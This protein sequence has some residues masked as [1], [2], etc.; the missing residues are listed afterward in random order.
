MS[1]LFDK[2]RVLIKE[3]S[4]YKKTNISKSISLIEEAISLCP[5]YVLSDYYKLSSYYHLAGKKNKAYEL[6]NQQ[7][8]YLNENYKLP[9]LHSNKA[10]IYE[11]IGVLLYSDKMYNEYIYNFS[12]E[13]FN[14][15][16]S[17]FSQGRIHDY[18]ESKESY[19][20]MGLSYFQKINKCFYNIN[21]SRITAE[22]SITFT[23]LFK[24]CNED[25][26]MLMNHCNSYLYT[27]QVDFSWP[28]GTKALVEENAKIFWP[29]RIIAIIQKYNDDYFKNYFDSHLKLFLN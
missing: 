11:H 9:V 14:T 20:I 7:I 1:D 3:S 16:L 22:Y 15:N 6:L 10:T 27:S 19:D 12:L 25:L 2:S 24:E 17:V 8:V 5:E 13:R 28:K 18:E 29:D 23:K 26:I 21:K 4:Q